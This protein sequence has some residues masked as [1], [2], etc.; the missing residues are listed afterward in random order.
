MSRVDAKSSPA[1]QGASTSSS[2]GTGPAH[3]LQR[4][5]STHPVAAAACRF[6]RL[7]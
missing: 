6:K 2:K 4:R 3:F 5:K 1:Q 7:I